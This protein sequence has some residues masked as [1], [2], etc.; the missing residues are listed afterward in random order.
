MD[1]QIGKWF[2]E[3]KNVRYAY[4]AFP[5]AQKIRRSLTI[6]GL[7]SH[8]NRPGAR[9]EWGS[10]LTGTDEQLMDLMRACVPPDAEQGIPKK[11]REEYAKWLLHDIEYAVSGKH[12]MSWVDYARGYKHAH[13]SSQTQTDKVE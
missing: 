10:V 9:R 13:N 6:S 2:F 3:N 1:Q 8:R 7:V 11:A 12:R 4:E 5:W